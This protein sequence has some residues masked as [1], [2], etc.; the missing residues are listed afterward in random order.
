M[1]RS[2]WI[3]AVKGVYCGEFP[4]GLSPSLHESEWMNETKKVKAHAE[5]TRREW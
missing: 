3:L 4:E 5:R 1:V 2:N